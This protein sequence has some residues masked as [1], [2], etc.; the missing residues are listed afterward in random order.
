MKHSY[1]L[2]CFFFTAV[3]ACYSQADWFVS[4]GLGP[5]NYVGDLRDKRFTTTGMKLNGSLG[6]TYQPSPHISWN[7]TFTAGKIAATDE[8]NGPKWKYRNLSFQTLLFEGALT[9]EWDFYDITQ[10]EN[11]FADQNPQKFTPFLFA[12]VALFHFNP[13]TYDQAGNK[14]HLEPLGTEG[15]TNP[16]SLWQFAIP[17]GIGA[18]YALNNTTV[19]SAEFNVRKTFTDYIDDVSHFHYVDTTALLASHGQEAASLSYRAD[20]IPN[21]PYS[22]KDGYRG[23]PNKKDGYY[24]FMIKVSFQLFTNRPQFY[25]GY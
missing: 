9:G 12:G 19:I 21:N 25:Y 20:E 8:Q 24:S 7:F 22:F 23:N 13:Y 10:P 18:K 2:F 4:A 17:F 15:Q 3:T 14:V 16:Y 6:L 11:S 5:I 1:F